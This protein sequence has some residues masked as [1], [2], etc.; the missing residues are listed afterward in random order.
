M[1]FLGTEY[2]V[3]SLLWLS[4][5]AAFVFAFRKPIMKLFYKKVTLDLF[6][7]KLHLYLAKTYPDIKFDY[8]IIEQSKEEQNPE[9]RKFI[10]VDHIINQFKSI[11]IKTEKYHKNTPKDLQWSSYLFNCEPNKDKLPK[12]WMQR[13]NALFVRD[14]RKCF[15]CSTYIDIQTMH[16]KMIIPLKDGGK[17]YLENLIPLCADCDKLLSDD[18]KKKNGFLNIKDKLYHIVETT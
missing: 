14:H 3:S 18:S 5:I 17:Y 7:N 11:Q 15:R 6:I 9:L 4:V 10:I 13:K 16:P 12:D 1:Y 2:I 8:S